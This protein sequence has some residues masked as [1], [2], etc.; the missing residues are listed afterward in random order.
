MAELQSLRDGRD[1]LRELAE[2]KREMTEMENFGG[3]GGAEEAKEK[4][5]KKNNIA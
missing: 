5:G 1:V 4:D 3:G 2:R